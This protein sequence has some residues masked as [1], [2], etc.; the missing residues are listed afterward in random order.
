MDALRGEIETLRTDIH[1]T[2]DI[3]GQTAGLLAEALPRLDDVDQRISRA[4][5]YLAE[6]LA[7]QKA[8]PNPPI[9]WPTLPAEQ[10][11]KRW[12]DLADWVSTILVGWYE[13]TRAQLPDCWPR[14]SPAVLELSWLRTTYVQ[15]YFPR[16]SPSLAAEWHVRWRPGA[17]ANIAAAIP[18]EWCRP[19]EHLVHELD[20][21]NRGHQ[22][23]GPTGSANDGDEGDIAAFPGPDRAEPRFWR[24]HLEQ[25]LADELRYR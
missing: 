16:S 13:L 1:A 21:A 15:A 22:S 12:H 23:A 2:N 3:H 8:P 5:T 11:E 4:E 25:A 14:H 17:L 20:L 18:V 19:G 10:V 9:H 24:P 6:L 7:E